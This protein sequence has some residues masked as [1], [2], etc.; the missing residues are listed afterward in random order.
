MITIDGLDIN[1]APFAIR[2][3]F[4]FPTAV[5]SSEMVQRSIGS[6]LVK[7]GK[8]DPVTVEVPMWITGVAGGGK[9]AEDKALE[10][11]GLIAQKREKAEAMAGLG[12]LAGTVKLTGATNDS[13]ITIMQIEVDAPKVDMLHVHAQKVAFTLKLTLH[14]LILGPEYKV[15]EGIKPQGVPAADIT[16]TGAKGDIP[17]PAR[18]VVTPIVP[19]LRD[20]QFAVM[21]LQWRTASSSTDLLVPPST[22]L[23]ASYGAT[24]SNGTNE[25]QTATKS[26][27]IS[28][29]TFTLSVGGS[30]TPALAHDASTATVKAAVEALPAVGTSNVNVTGSPLSSGNMIFT[31][32]GDLA[33]TP[34]ALLTLTSSL[35]G[36]GSVSL[37][38]TTVGV[39]GYIQSAP[40]ANRWSSFAQ[41]YAQADTG[42]YDIFALVQTDAVPN[43]MRVRAAVS[44]SDP[45]RN[46][47]NRAALVPVSNVPVWVN[48]GP[49]HISADDLP[50][51]YGWQA[52]VQAY[53]TGAAGSY[54]RVLSILK[55]PTEHGARSA[56][57]GQGNV[58]STV[59]ADSFNQS[60]GNYTGKSMDIGGTVSGGG[61][62][63]DFTINTTSHQ[64]Q[65]SA[66]SDSASTGRRVWST[67]SVLTGHSATLSLNWNV[68]GTG[69]WGARKYGL[70]FRYVDSSNFGVAVIENTGSEGWSDLAIYKVVSGTWTRLALSQAAIAS[71][72]N[73][74]A[75]LHLTAATN[76]LIT[77]TCTG[78]LAFLQGATITASDPV[79]ASGGALQQGYNGIY[80]EHTNANA[81]T[82]YYDSFNTSSVPASDAVCFAIEFLEWRNNGQFQ[83]SR[84]YTS[85]WAPAQGQQGAGLPLIGPDGSDGQINK[86]AI[87]LADFNPDVAAST[88]SA[89]S[90]SY[91]VYHRPAYLLG[92]HEA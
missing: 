83:R 76:G 18:V 46:V 81:L 84:A 89:A 91:D 19:T 44:G 12:G 57:V 87:A 24:K 48:L 14:P 66:V 32:T 55:V 92:R 62:S 78:N 86:L 43:T 71:P 42:S 74:S 39:Y 31:F 37:T 26:G 45:T 82:R 90:F 80:D 75:S 47:Y 33:A 54:C 23:Y 1:A 34:V 59:L 51:W 67:T 41:T 15:A 29:G 16:I 79:F 21:G 53:A 10:A 4:D 65:R 58:E 5:R 40:V 7:G 2:E 36:G 52:I 70:I 13:Q 17:G 61:D 88:D 72:S 20:Q 69:D 25:V 6:A 49:A 68:T 64:L 73:V 38:R 77:L 8:R 11:I 35:T 85:F 27:T 22:M 56:R 3:G 9:T 28:G 50:S 63:D 60:S 30:T